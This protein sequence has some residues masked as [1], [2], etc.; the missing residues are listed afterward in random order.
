[1]S[2]LCYTNQ[3]KMA[4]QLLL[5]K[6]KPEH[7]AVLSD[8]EVEAM[9]LQDYDLYIKAKPDEEFSDYVLVPK[10]ALLDKEK[11]PVISR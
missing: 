5:K 3:F 4:R 7:L 2:H 10:G 6:M 8:N 1:M 11:Y 9:L